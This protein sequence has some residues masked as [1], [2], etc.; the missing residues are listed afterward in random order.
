MINFEL[1]GTLKA[2]KDKDDFHAWETKDFGSGWQTTRYRFN[3][4]S[5]N[6]RFMCEIGG[7]KWTDD[8]KNKILTM[9]RAAAGEKPQKIEV[10]WEDRRNPEIIEKVSGFR[11]YTCNLL[12]L[13]EAKEMDEEEAK[14]KN[15]QYIEPT[16]Y[17]ALVKRVVDSDKYTNT[18]FKILGTI[19]FQYNEKKG[20][21]YRTMTVNKIYKV[22]DDTPC[23]SE[24]T[25]NAFYTADSMNTDSFDETQ[26]YYFNCYTDQYFSTVKENRFVPMTLIIKGDGD[27]EKLANAF[28][29]KLTAFDDEATVRKINLVCDAINGSETVAITYDDLDDDTKENVDLGLISLEDAIKGLGGNMVGNSVSEYRIKSFARSSAQGS[30]A[31][32]YTEE[33]LKKLPIKAEEVEE[34]IEDVFPEDEDDDI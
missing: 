19:D 23:K 2:V 20:Q 24:I 14:K 6:N 9:S 21:Y 10:A 26:K 31:T 33:D 29:K 5:G 11:I 12:T 15:H 27:N 3:V 22:T 1:V 13:D 34:I 25:I 18:K 7:G 28:K 30:E 17:A 8:S 16:E 4:I 32:V